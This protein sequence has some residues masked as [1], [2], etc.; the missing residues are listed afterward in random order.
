MSERTIILL[1]CIFIFPGG[2]L[3]VG[4]CGLTYAV[5]RQWRRTGK[6]FTRAREGR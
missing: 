5:V 4:L 1:S 3:F 6:A 2:A